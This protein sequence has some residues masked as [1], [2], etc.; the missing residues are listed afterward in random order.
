MSV[1]DKVLATARRPSPPLLT[2][3]RPLRP[4]PRPRVKVDVFMRHNKRFDGLLRSPREL[5]ANI[6]LSKIFTAS[7]GKVAA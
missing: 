3:R 1:S 5:T 6:C 4:R 7:L 2:L